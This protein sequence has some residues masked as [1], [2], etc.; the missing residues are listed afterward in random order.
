MFNDRIIEALAEFNVVLP[1]NLL[2]ALYHHEHSWLVVVL[3][4]LRLMCVYTSALLLYFE[5]VRTGF[6]VAA[7]ALGLTLCF[8][9]LPAH[10]TKHQRLYHIVCAVMPTNYIL[11]TCAART[12][13]FKSVYA[14][15][16]IVI[17]AS[18]IGIIIVESYVYKDY[19]NAW[20]CYQNKKINAYNLGPCPLYTHDY[21][22]D[23][24]CVNNQVSNLPCLGRQSTS[25]VKSHWSRHGA[26]IGT[27]LLLAQHGV[28][29]VIQG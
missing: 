24:A 15:I 29:A 9:A 10:S 7:A 11:N 21:Q 28:T 12:T 14:T 22:H 3:S 23:W 26:C 2:V 1:I 8:G 25:W 17:R 27:A 13:Q 19:G 6:I 20:S 18:L 5:H 16:Q 4:A